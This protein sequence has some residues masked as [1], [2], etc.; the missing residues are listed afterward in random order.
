MKNYNHIELKDKSRKCMQ[1]LKYLQKL[2]L[3]RILISAQPAASPRNIQTL[4]QQTYK[5][6]QWRS[7][8]TTV[9]HKPTKIKNDKNKPT[10]IKK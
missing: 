8:S 6:F 1:I 5:H 9:T 4:R 2:H 7:N 3:A 10:K